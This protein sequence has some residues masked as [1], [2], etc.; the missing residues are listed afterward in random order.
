MLKK[1]SW[2]GFD[3]SFGYDH[4]PKSVTCAF[5]AS[6]FFYSWDRYINKGYKVLQFV[7]SQIWSTSTNNVVTKDVKIPKNL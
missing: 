4:I 7:N 5:L 2:P 1:L 3:I 6:P